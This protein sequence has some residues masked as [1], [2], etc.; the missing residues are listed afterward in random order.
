[1]AIHHERE[2]ECK[3]ANQ[4]RGGASPAIENIACVRMLLSLFRNFGGE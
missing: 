2:A 1:M 4:R 3:S